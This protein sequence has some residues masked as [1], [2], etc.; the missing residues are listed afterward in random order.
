M[1]ASPPLKLGMKMLL[2]SPGST[3]N[4]HSPNFS[5]GGNRAFSRAEGFDR[6]RHAWGG[7]ETGGLKACRYD[8]VDSNLLGNAVLVVVL[9]NVVDDAVPLKTTHRRLP[10]RACTR[11]VPAP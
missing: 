5:A 8:V 1:A 11:A 7:G 9:G 6:C 2:H 10:A 3:I 4:Q